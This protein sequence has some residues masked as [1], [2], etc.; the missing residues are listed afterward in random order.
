MERQEIIYFDISILFS[1]FTFH[2]GF[3]TNYLEITNLNFTIII[4]NL[5]VTQGW[6]PSDEAKDWA[7]TEL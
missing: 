4:I 5:V 1:V 6:V 7:G 2:V 3:Q